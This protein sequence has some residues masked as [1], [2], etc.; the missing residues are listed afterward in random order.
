M[1]KIQRKRIMTYFHTHTHTN[2]LNN[3]RFF[4]SLLFVTKAAK[5]KNN[6]QDNFFFVCK[7]LSDIWFEGEARR[8]KKTRKTKVQHFFSVYM[9]KKENE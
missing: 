4:F 5:Q 2:I 9:Q 7:E 3:L 6:R 8:Q 1:K